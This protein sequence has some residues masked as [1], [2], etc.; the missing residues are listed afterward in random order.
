M[1]ED[2]PAGAGA[3]A[4]TGGT[5]AVDIEGLQEVGHGLGTLAEQLGSALRGVDALPLGAVAPVLGPVGAD[6]LAAL[7]AATARHREVLSDLVRVTG[8]A[9]DLVLQSSR[10]LSDADAATAAGIGSA[11]AATEGATSADRVTEV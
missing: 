1:A 9:G 11:G 4:V 7:H 10:L 5:T 2:Q 3:P 6:F 8:A